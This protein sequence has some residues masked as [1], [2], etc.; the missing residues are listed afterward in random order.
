MAQPSGESATDYPTQRSISRP[1]PYH[2]DT[3]EQR[4]TTG[5]S[6]RPEP[7]SWLFQFSPDYKWTS[8]VFYFLEIIFLGFTSLCFVIPW[9]YLA[10]TLDYSG[11]VGGFLCAGLRA[12]PFPHPVTVWLSAFL[13]L[14]AKF[15]VGRVTC[16][17]RAVPPPSLCLS[18]GP[19]PLA[20]LPVLLALSFSAFSALFS[21]L[22]LWT[23]HRVDFVLRFRRR[24]F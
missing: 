19:A 12:S 8:D 18:S 2:H 7:T 17:F 6:Q 1:F 24:W 10:P 15:C 13:I 4:D 11:F 22:V 3:F 21:C 23:C 5:Q 14:L 20:G 9:D 16:S